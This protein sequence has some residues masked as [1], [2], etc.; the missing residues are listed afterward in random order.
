MNQIESTQISRRTALKAAGTFALAPALLA[1]CGSSG[2]GSSSGGKV[3]LDFWTHTDPPLVDVTKAAVASFE[4]ANPDISIKY[5][6]IP[7]AQFFTKMLTSMSTGSGPDVFDMNDN[8]VAGDYI[9]RNLLAPIDPSAMGY[10]SIDKLKAAYA[11]GSLGGA[12]GPDG[13]IYGVPLELDAAA[14][15]INTTLF[16]QAGLDPNTPPKTWTDVGTMGAKIAK[17]TGAQGYNVVWLSG[18]GLLQLSPLLLQ[19]GARVVDSSG[20]K[21]LINNAAGI[22]AIEIWNTLFNIDHA[23]NPHTATRNSTVPYY[24]FA[25]GKQGMTMIFPWAVAQIQKQYPKLL[26]QMKIVPLP[27]IDPST[28]HLYDYG[29]SWSVSAHASKDKQHAA[30][31]FVRHL[32]DQHSSYLGSAG[33]V[34]PVTGWQTSPAGKTMPFSQEWAPIYAK[35]EFMPV[36]TNWSQ[37]G[38]IMQTAIEDVLLNGKSAQSALDSAASHQRSRTLTSARPSTS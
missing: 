36:S 18:W 30:W 28:P 25:V 5:T 6:T 20:K 9:P 2:G 7:N 14:L 23:G 34:Q 33:L 37:V 26:D 16:K 24:D 1:A 13:S 15:A 3:S 27:Q 10:G 11:P 4:K 22:Q 32:A 17:A 35:S 8:Y 29:Y 31:K 12:T 38:A 19:T 21:A